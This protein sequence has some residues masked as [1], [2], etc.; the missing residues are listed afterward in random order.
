MRWKPL[1]M[2][3]SFV[4]IGIFMFLLIFWM[5]S[6]A[7]TKRDLYRH[8][9]KRKNFEL[10]TFNERLFV[11]K[12]QNFAVLKPKIPLDSSI[13]VKVNEKA[14]LDNVIQSIEKHT[15]LPSKKVEREALLIMSS[16]RTGSSF[17]GQ[18]FNQHPDVFY[19]FEPLFPFHDS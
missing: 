16:M 14:H 18:F 2:L 6:E 11:E 13:N 3:Q 10:L 17:T 15:Q 4:C 5:S 12:N 8:F 19:I 1:C 9:Q 7:T